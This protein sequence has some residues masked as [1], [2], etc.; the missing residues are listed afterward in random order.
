[1]IQKLGDDMRCQSENVPTNMWYVF[2][3][4]SILKTIDFCAA[5]RSAVIDDKKIP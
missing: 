1:M 2:G 4:E 3:L 5:N